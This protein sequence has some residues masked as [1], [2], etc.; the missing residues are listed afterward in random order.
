MADAQKPRC[1]MVDTQATARFSRKWR[2]LRGRTEADFPDEWRETRE[3]LRRV[4]GLQ[5]GEA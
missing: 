1:P 2:P 3:N 4:Q 5:G